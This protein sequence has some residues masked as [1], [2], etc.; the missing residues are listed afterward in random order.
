MV[1]PLINWQYRDISVSEKI[2]T[3]PLLEKCGRYSMVSL[4]EERGLVTPAAPS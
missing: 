4:L 2:Q 1:T 3:V